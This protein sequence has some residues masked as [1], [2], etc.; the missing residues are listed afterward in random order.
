MAEGLLTE[1]V[2]S[3]GAVSDARPSRDVKG[4]H[5]GSL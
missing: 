2:R 5:Y 3:G 1:A 4:M